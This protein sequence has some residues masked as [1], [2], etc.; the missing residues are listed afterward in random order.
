[1]GSGMIGEL[2][3]AIPTASFMNLL[4]EQFNLKVIRHTAFHKAEVKKIAVCGGAG[5][6]LLGHAK[7]AGAD[8]FVTADFKYHEFF[9]AEEKIIISDIGHYESEV[10]TK[11]LICN[12][13]KEKFANIAL[14][15]SEVDTNPIKYF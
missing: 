14:N 1:V 6:F 13:L 11:E 2:E 10:F 12:F 15:L 5:S 8:V 9:D 4:K 7:G 3:T